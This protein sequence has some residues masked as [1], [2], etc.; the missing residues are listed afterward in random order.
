MRDNGFDM[1]DPDF[2]RFALPG[3]DG[4]GAGPFGDLDPEDPAFEQ[5][6]QSCED[7]LPGF[8]GPGGARSGG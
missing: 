1:P 2:S 3:E 5:A 4:P 7:S 6:F 8:T